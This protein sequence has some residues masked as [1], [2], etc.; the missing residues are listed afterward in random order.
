MGMRIGI[1]STL[2]L[3]DVM[4]RAQKEFGFKTHGKRMRGSGK[5]S[6]SHNRINR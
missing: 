2:E 6:T 3:G 4:I 1:E 5:P